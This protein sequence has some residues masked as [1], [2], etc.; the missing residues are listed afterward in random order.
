MSEI[1]YT[2]GRAKLESNGL[3]VSYQALERKC[4][5]NGVES[6][7]E[8]GDRLRQGEINQDYWTK[9][10][11][12]QNDGNERAQRLDVA[13]RELRCHQGLLTRPAGAIDKDDET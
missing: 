6:R 7:I 3:K 5:E 12:M 1:H 4:K 11:D 8:S 13:P 2:G 10:L 9:M